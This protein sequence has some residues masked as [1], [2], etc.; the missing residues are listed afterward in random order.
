M[1]HENRNSTAGQIQ[2]Y[3]S[4]IWRSSAYVAENTLLLQYK[5]TLMQFR[6][7][8]SLFRESHDINIYG[9]NIKLI[10][11]ES[12]SHTVI[13]AHWGVKYKCGVLLL[14]PCVSNYSI[15]S[16]WANTKGRALISLRWH[17]I[18]PPPLPAPSFFHLAIKTSLNIPPTFLFL[19]GGMVG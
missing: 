19:T 13:T 16:V 18:M 9:Q 3:S 1:C 4:G 14:R 11:C 10:K 6:N 5:C 8:I 15:T 17:K 7:K 2:V 12:R